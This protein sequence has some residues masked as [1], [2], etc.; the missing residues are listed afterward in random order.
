[1]CLG[2]ACENGHFALPEDCSLCSTAIDAKGA[3]ALS[4]SGTTGIFTAMW[5][6]QGGHL[7]ARGGEREGQEGISRNTVDSR[8]CSGFI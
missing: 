4:L 3:Q 7:C 8:Q 1:M 2:N 5:V 6:L